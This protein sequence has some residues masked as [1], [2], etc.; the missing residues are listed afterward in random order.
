MF[1]C[2]LLIAQVLCV[3]GDFEN[4]LHSGKLIIVTD[5]VCNDECTTVVS[6]IRKITGNY[7][8]ADIKKNSDAREY[9]KAIDYRGGYP[10]YFYKSQFVSD[11]THDPELS[12]ILMGL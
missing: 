2:L 10:V 7:Y 9:M 1:K 8:L 4:Q 6:K 3:F 12:S 11:V 5:G